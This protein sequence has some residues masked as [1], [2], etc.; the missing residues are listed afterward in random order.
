MAELSPA[1]QAVVQAF[2]DRYEL[3]CL[4]THPH[5]VP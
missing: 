5:C 2:D 4:C 1:A 3:S